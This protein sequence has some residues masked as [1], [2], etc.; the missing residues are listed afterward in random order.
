[1]AHCLVC[2]SLGTIK[3]LYTQN[4]EAVSG[5]WADKLSLA[6]EYTEHWMK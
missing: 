1:M 6:I 5:K 3:S 4:E 2:G